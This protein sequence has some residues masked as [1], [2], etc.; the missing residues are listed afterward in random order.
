MSRFGALISSSVPLSIL[1]HT[2]MVAKLVGPNGGLQ[3]GKWAVH[4]EQ[5]PWSD[6]YVAYMTKWSK[7]P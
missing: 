1:L 3:V 6:P 5:A 2:A 7:N 4:D